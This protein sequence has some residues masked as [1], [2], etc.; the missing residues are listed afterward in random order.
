M[1]PAVPLLPVCGL[2]F[3]TFLMLRLSKI[4]W[5]RFAIWCFIGK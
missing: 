4:T 3:N 1:A 5:A 2:W